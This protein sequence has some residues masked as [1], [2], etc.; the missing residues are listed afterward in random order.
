MVGGG[1]LLMSL[2]SKRRFFGSFSI[3]TTHPLLLSSYAQDS[4]AGSIAA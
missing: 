1:E 3:T 2:L 4:L